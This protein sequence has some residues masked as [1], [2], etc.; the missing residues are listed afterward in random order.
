M[1]LSV[2]ILTKN[3]EKNIVEC[4]KSL[5]FADEIIVVDDDS[6]DNTAQVS[7]ELGARVFT[8]KL[9]SNFAAQRNYGLEKAR[10]S[11]VLFI[12]AD[13]L[14]SR[15]LRD[16][17]IQTTSNPT[18]SYSGFYI[19]RADY[20]WGKELKYG[21]T[22][23]IKLLRLAKGNIGKWKRRVHEVWEIEGNK[24][25]L[26]NPIL[27]YPHPTVADFVVHI[28]RYSTLHA[29]ANKEE[30]KSASVIKI[31]VWPIGKFIHN[32]FIKLGFLD[33]I[34]GFI[35]ALSMSFSSFLA[36]SKIWL[37]QNQS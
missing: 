20:L 11:W 27:H 10:G 32:Y 23:K 3:E 4:L 1:N 30:G 17:I 22:G 31:I 25:T 37:I 24:L 18:H 9:N 21:E 16:E 34:V 33:G 8:R 14:V 28:N 5:S 29:K 13:E 36:W 35:I 2:V 7:K 6:T 19:K 26:K 15:A 12:D